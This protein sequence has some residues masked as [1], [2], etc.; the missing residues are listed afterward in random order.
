MEIICGVS[1]KYESWT[2][3]FINSYIANHTLTYY[4]SENHLGTNYYLL[5]L[6]TVHSYSFSSV[7]YNNFNFVNYEC[8]NKYQLTITDKTKLIHNLKTKGSYSG[9][10]YYENVNY[11]KNKQFLIFKKLPNLFLLLT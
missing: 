1:S 4:V 6:K 10:Y 11:L 7:Q 3:N 2:H 9:L 5:Q 8:F